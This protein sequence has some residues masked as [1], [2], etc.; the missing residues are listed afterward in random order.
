MNIASTAIGQQV[1]SLRRKSVPWIGK[2][3]LSIVDQGFISGSNFLVAIVLARWLGAAEYGGYALAF[4][5]FL[6]LTSVHQA[7]VIEPMVVLAPSC[8]R[9]RI[10]AY[11]G[12]LITFQ[13]KFSLPVALLLCFAAAICFKTERSL[14]GPFLGLAFAAPSIMVFWVARVGSYVSLTPAAAAQA[15][16]VYSVTLFG[17]LL[18]LHRVSCV[19]VFSCFLIMSVAALVGACVLLLKLKVPIRRPEVQRDRFPK[20]WNQ[21]W[22]YGHWELSTMVVGWFSDNLWYILA[23]GYF[24]M[25]EVGALRAIVNLFLPILQTLTALRRIALPYLSS[26]SHQEGDSAASGPSNAI[27]FLSG[28]LAFA[29]CG[30]LILFSGPVFHFFYGGRFGQFA[31]L[32]PWVALQYIFS[33]AA[34]GYQLAL[35]AAQRPSLVF[36]ARCVEALVFVAAS[37]PATM[38]FGL[39]G[40]VAS[41]ALSKFVLVVMSAVLMR[42][43]LRAQ[44]LL[45]YRSY[46]A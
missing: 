40:M 32:M 46:A 36:C 30:T 41:G 14:T 34:L 25:A 12:R 33:S 24:G 43:K 38:R 4:S 22:G 16:V 39:L 3:V 42:Y 28:T 13:A 11:V 44:S 27:A 9:S 5:I 7:V 31:Y 20:L 2:G 17:S 26:K 29:Y 15:A 6:L 45:R 35:R 8:Y 23:A 10:P 21:H 1:R 18:L 37:I 19:S